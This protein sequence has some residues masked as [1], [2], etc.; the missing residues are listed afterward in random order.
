VRLTDE[1]WDR[2]YTQLWQ[3][4]W[5]A[6]R[7]LLTKLAEVAKIPGHSREAFCKEVSFLMGRAREDW[8]YRGGPR[9]AP[10]AN[11]PVNDELKKAEQAV[12]VARDAVDALSDEQRML[13]AK[14]MQAQNKEMDFETALTYFPRI[15]PTIADAIA[16][17]T[18]TNPGR[19][20]SARPGRPRGAVGDWPFYH[21][22]RSLWNLVEQYDGKLTLTTKDGVVKSGTLPTVLKL[23]KP[24]EFKEQDGSARMLPSGLIPARLPA[25][26]LEKIKKEVV[27]L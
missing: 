26:V 17:V 12:R 23:L 4:E 6:S 18:G 2:R 19:H 1:E 10:T 8:R 21:F 9:S 13:I 11:A 14:A 5:E 3:A 16:R 15:L 7:K 24:T 25:K 20:P 27:P 22:V